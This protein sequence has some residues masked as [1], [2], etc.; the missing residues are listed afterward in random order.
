M[1]Q[2]GLGQAVL[3]GIDARGAALE[4]CTFTGLTGTSLTLAG[5]SLTEVTFSGSRFVGLDLD[6]ATLRS[7]KF[8][9]VQIDGG[10]LVAL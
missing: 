10:S 4:S 5:G 1:K 6:G 3:D 9:N 7:V 2:V 8:E